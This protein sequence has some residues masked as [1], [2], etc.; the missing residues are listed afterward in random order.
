MFDAALARDTQKARDIL[1][2]HIRNGL[3]HTLEAM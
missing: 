3:S 1:E 2:A